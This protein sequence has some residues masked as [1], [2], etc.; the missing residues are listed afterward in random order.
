MPDHA[1]L[2]KVKED[3]EKGLRAIPGVHAV[4]I[5]KKSVNG[6]FTDE[7]AIAVF[8]TKKKPLSELAPHEVVPSQINGIKDRCYRTSKT[9]FDD[10]CESGQPSVCRERQPA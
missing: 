5:G 9:A 1:Q 10:G 2:V 3:A 6:A 7:L 4:G 8:V